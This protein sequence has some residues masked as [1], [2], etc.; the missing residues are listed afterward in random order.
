[1]ENEQI[2][3]G[4]SQIAVKSLTNDDL[5]L[6]EMVKQTALLT[7]IHTLLWFLV[8]IGCGLLIVYIIVKP[9]YNLMLGRW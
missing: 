6:Q 7:N 9:I 5:L 3:Q 4:V 2:L 1:M 8:V